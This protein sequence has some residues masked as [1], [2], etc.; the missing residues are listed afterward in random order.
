[1]EGIKNT[2]TFDLGIPG[3]AEKY[4]ADTILLGKP[5][6]EAPLGF[7]SKTDFKK[8]TIPWEEFKAKAIGRG[9]KVIDIRDYI[10]K[11]YMTPAVEAELSPEE[12]KN[13]DE[14]RAK[15]RIMLME[16]GKQKIIAQS[17]DIFQ[18]NISENTLY[19]S[20]TMLIIDQVG[21]QVRWLMYSLEAAGVKDY[22]F[23]ADGAYGVIGIQA[24]GN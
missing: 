19:K 20:Q 11:G 14:F 23:L 15:N 6:P 7:I 16:L 3:W 9:V 10:Q 17:I 13:L 24:Y 5:I 22:Y 12:K 18:K 8:K 1:M 2:F 4:P 21:K